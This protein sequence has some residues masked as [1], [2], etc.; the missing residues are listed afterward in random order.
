MRLAPFIVANTEIILQAWE[1]FART[2]LPGAAMDSLALRDHAADI[3]LATVR[4]MES[5]QTE[6][7][8]SDKSG[9]Y[10]DG[11]DRSLR[12]NGATADHA[13]GRL[14]AGFN[15]TQLVSEYRALRASVLS[16]WRKNSPETHAQ[17]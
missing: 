6:Q 11:S 16:L 14:G 17:D 1:T 4:D 7:L 15:M 5:V 10:S 12:L 13:I 9:G 2:I 3:L 8:R